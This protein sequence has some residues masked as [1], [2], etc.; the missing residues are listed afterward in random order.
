MAYKFKLKEAPAPNLAKQGGYKVGDVTYSNDGDT[1]FT[2]DAVNPESGK[3]SWKITNLPNFD[4]LFDELRD[5]T[6]TAKGVYTKVKDDEK[7]REIYEDIRL[8]RNKVRTHL[9]KEYPEDYKRMTINEDDMDEASM[10]GAAGAYNT[11]YAFNKNKKEDG[12][13]NDSAYTSIGYKAVKEKA[14]NIIR[15]KLAKVPKAKKVTSKQKMKL[16]SGMVSSFGVAE[17][18]ENPGATLG[19]G[20]AASEDGVKDNY[21]VKGFKYK[22]VPKNKQ[23]TYVQ[24]GSSMPVRKLWG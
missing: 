19:P 17:S 15:K 4:K 14:E 24:K 11:P 5:A 18:K 12:T 22:L 8:I 13:D 16:P 3:V 7:F 23:G 21:Y 2:V 1:R 10:S 9:R 20:P 6:E